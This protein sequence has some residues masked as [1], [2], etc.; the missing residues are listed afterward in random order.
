MRVALVGGSDKKCFGLLVEPLDKF[1]IDFWTN[2]LIVQNSGQKPG[3]V[4]TFARSSSATTLNERNVRV[5]TSLFLGTRQLTLVECEM[6]APL[7][8]MYCKIMS[9]VVSVENFVT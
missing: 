9:A 6:L 2:F 8:R 3:V 7:V 4:M 1:T 5:D